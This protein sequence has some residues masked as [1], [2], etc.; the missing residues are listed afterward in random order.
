[1]KEADIRPAAILDEYLRLCREDIPRFFA[2]AKRADLPC[3]ACGSVDTAQAFEKEG[4][5]YR[6]CR[7]CGT[8]YQAPRPT[9]EAFEKFYGDSASSSYWAN[10][11]FP[12]VAE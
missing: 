8:L 6:Q 1:M 9:F 4:F 3:V 10:V 11:F 2:G 12:S 7:G 5:G